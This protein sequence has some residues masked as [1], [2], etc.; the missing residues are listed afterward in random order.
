VLGVDARDH[1]HVLGEALH[2]QGIDREV[3]GLV[4]RVEQFEDI[5]VVRPHEVRTVVVIGDRSTDE[6]RHRVERLAEDAVEAGHRR[7]VAERN[8]GCSRHAGSS[9]GR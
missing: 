2:H 9:L 4:V 8:F 5:G 3:L 6:L 1:V 7:R